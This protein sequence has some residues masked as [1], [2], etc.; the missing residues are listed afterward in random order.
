MTR[1][2]AVVARKGGAGKSTTV[3]N[4]A[5][6]L[7][8][9][10]QR[11][12][13][14]DMD[15]QA[16]LTGLFLGERTGRGIGEALIDPRATLAPLVA[17]VGGSLFP[18]LFLVPGNRGIERAAQELSDTA[19]GFLRLRKLL[20]GLAGFDTIIVDTPPA[21]GFAISSALLAAQQAVLPTLTGQLDLDA[22]TDT[23]GVIESQQELGGALLTAVVPCA[24]R[25]REVHDR[26][27]LETLA[28]TFGPLL[29]PAV[30]YSPRVRESLIAHEP[31]ASYDPR[32]AAAEAYAALA[33]RLVPEGSPHA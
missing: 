5:G 14:V 27:A 32:S 33:E 22:L 31:L 28:A 26:G 15:P 2:I 4:V 19:T 1:I 6:A 30:P 21:L 7:A 8:H 24:V 12:L 11:V 16:S 17:A 20:A 13:I 10:G 29:T 23:V 9:R 18:T 25:P 3:F